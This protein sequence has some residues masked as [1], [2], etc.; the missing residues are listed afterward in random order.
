MILFNLLEAHFI[1]QIVE[2][3]LGRL[4][5]PIGTDSEK[6]GKSAGECRAP[7]PSLAGNSCRG[8]TKGGDSAWTT[9]TMS[10]WNDPSSALLPRRFLQLSYQIDRFS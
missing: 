9:S 8:H 2:A 4:Y 7:G 1:L 3:A 6:A 5:C 10:G